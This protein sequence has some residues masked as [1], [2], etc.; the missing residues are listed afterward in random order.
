MGGN[1]LGIIY[2]SHVGY[3]MSNITVIQ[4]YSTMP[5]TSDVV[6]EQTLLLYDLSLSKNHNT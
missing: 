3:K 4:C 2:T 6:Y 5:N 1:L